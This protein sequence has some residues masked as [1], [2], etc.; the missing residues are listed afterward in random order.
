MTKFSL[1]PV[2]DSYLLVV[3][4]AL[5]L[6]GLLVLILPRGERIDRWRRA[7]LLGLRIAMILLVILVML[8]PAI[9]YSKIE[10]KSATLILLLDAS[11]SMTVA[12]A[13][14]GKTRW[15]ALK[16]AV[17]DAQPA[18]AKLAEDFELK[19]FTF[20]AQTHPLTVEGGKIALP[21]K[22]EGKETAYGFAL[23]EVMQ[24]EGG[25]R[26]LG[27]VLI[28]DGR[29][30]TRSPR[31]KPPQTAAADMKRQGVP[32][33]AMPLGESR[34]RSQSKDLWVKDLLVN[35][36]VFVKNE[37]AIGA[38]VRV[39]G[40]LGEKIPVRLL[41]ETAPGRMEVVG[42]TTVQA[43]AN[44]QVM[45]VT[46][47]YAPQVPG[48]YKLTLE[49]PPQPGEFT[50]NNNQASTFVNVLKGGVNA[51]YIE[52]ALRVEQKFIRRALDSSP[53]IHVDYLRIDPRRPETRPGDLADRFQPG[54]YEVYILGD[55][56][57]EAFRGKELEDLAAAAER[58]A[59][60]IML[61]GFHS[62][63]P[64]GYA[65]TPLAQVLPVKLDRFERQD[66]GE[67]IRK[68]IH[69]PGPLRMQPTQLGLL[70][71]AM[72]LSADRPE[73]LASWQ[74][75]PPLDGANKFVGLKTGAL[76]LAVADDAT[77]LLVAHNY[78][79]GRVLAFAGDST[80][81]WWM[82]GFEKTHKRF[83]RQVVLWLAKKDQSSDGAVWVK[84]E[85]RIYAPGDQVKCTVGAQSPTGETL[86]DAAYDAYLALPDGT[87]RPVRLA[88]V[89]DTMRGT[90]RETLP[91]ADYAIEVSASHKGMAVGTARARFIVLKEDLEMD[92]TAA[93]ADVMKTLAAKTGGE[94][95]APEQLDQLVERLAKQTDHLEV[96][97]ITRKSLW[98]TWPM[99]LA[100]VG[101]LGVE[102]F[103]RKRWGLV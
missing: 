77:P 48:E 52:G 87:R 17:A 88:R 6:L 103:L 70:H 81:R 24:Q 64:G 60:L 75:L 74:K 10:K 11:K 23:E 56:D 91:A 30:R 5:V 26:L 49:A 14:G 50:A 42:Q 15:E 19:A 3:A 58:G 51:L 32:L 92:N 55:L 22:A 36:E 7:G 89:D 28:G 39:D 29:Q 100:I 21:E 59:G 76:P 38:Q 73:N 86:A 71:F 40:Y 53:D 4:A 43:D 96:E 9:E 65:T 16:K 99:F 2:G 12:D 98:D 34:A 93:D 69:V 47:H 80:W 57:S 27:V 66:F 18:L 85:Q 82:R 35:N 44:G 90:F 97:Q 63:G 67:A 33:F 94:S 102:W 13:L 45:P 20:D 62:F 25:N 31:D 8:R 79:N 61:G 46:F 68:D 84:L 37:L 41:F 54:K 1:S 72:M 95:L 83:W 78:G 101:I